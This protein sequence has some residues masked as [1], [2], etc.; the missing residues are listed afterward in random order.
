[1]HRTPLTIILILSAVML[2]SCT[3]WTFPNHANL[4]AVPDPSVLNGA[5]S[6]LSL[7]T[8]ESN[9]TLWTVLTK[10]PGP[11]GYKPGISNQQ[12]FVL[13]TAKDSRHLIVELYNNSVLSS[14]KIL[15]GRVEDNYFR[16]KKRTRYFGLPFIYMSLSHYQLR[17][18]K[19]FSGKLLVDVAD[20]HGGMV[21]ILAGGDTNEFS[22]PYQSAPSP[23]TH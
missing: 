22:F 10:K 11:H 23:I 8:S 3:R 7:D 17:L 6:N 13:L 15:K 5:Y 16:P 1:M 4:T 2:Q 18:G 19:D 9:N 12:S 21:F 20:G 14:R